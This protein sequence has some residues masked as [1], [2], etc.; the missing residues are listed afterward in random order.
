[1]YWSY[2]TDDLHFVQAYFPGE[3]EIASSVISVPKE[4]VPVEISLKLLVKVHQ[5]TRHYS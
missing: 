4:L 2:C 3:K 1:M 5:S